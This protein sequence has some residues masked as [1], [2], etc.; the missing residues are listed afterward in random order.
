MSNTTE[1]YNNEVTKENVTENDT[2]I[3]FE[4][5]ENIYIVD[6]GDVIVHCISSKKFKKTRKDIIIKSRAQAIELINNKTRAKYFLQNSEKQYFLIN[7]IQAIN[8]KL[9]EKQYTTKYGREDYNKY[10]SDAK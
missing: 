2:P 6:I 10:V 9:F 3:T 4:T 5:N 8:S 1:S 7:N